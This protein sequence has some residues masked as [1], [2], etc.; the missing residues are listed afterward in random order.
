MAYEFV[1]YMKLVPQCFHNQ[2][3]HQG[4]YF[5]ES[6]DFWELIWQE[7]VQWCVLIDGIG[8]CGG[9][10]LRVLNVFPTFNRHR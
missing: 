6:F 8:R 2:N 10:G 7:L 1:G 9:K 4:N 5:V 3:W